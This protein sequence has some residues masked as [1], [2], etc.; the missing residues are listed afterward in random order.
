MNAFGIWTRCGREAQRGSREVCFAHH[1]SC[2][3]S[4]RAPDTASGGFA[5]AFLFDPSDQRSVRLAS[6]DWITDK[7]TQLTLVIVWPCLGLKSSSLSHTKHLEV[8]APTNSGTLQNDGWSIHA[9][10]RQSSRLAES[11][12]RALCVLSWRDNPFGLSVE[13]ELNSA[14]RSL[15]WTWNSHLARTNTNRWPR[16]FSDKL[17]QRCSSRGC[18][19]HFGIRTWAFF[20]V[21]STERVHGT[22]A[23]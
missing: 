14:S 18:V 19:R 8:A 17:R 22:I 13:S 11:E 23:A 6:G 12:T 20:F 21:P 10:G 3:F 4:Y 5:G 7:G 16:R 1:A 2:L 15:T 9:K